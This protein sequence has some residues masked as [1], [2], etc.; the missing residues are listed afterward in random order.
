MHTHT[1]S[2][3]H[4]DIHTHTHTLSFTHFHTHSNKHRDIHTH[5]HTFTHTQANTK[6]HTRKHTVMK[7]QNKEGRESRNVNESVLNILFYFL[8][9]LCPLVDDNICFQTASLTKIQF[10]N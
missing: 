4:K 5:T 2:S 8:Y 3:K 6:T 9:F 10:F 1:H 7:Q